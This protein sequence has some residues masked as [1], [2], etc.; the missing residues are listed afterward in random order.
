MIQ[1]KKK[2]KIQE[3][4]QNDVSGKQAENA[5]QDFDHAKKVTL[6]EQTDLSNLKKR[7]DGSSD[8]KT[9]KL[10]DKDMNPS[11]SETEYVSYKIIIFVLGAVICSHPPSS[12]H[13]PT[14]RPF[15]FLT[16]QF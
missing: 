6:H 11:P 12:P 5:Q 13:P 8:K 3:S 14:P 10:N 2:Q 16:S 15:S 9:V 7:K 4:I 1:R